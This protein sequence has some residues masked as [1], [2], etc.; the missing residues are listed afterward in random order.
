MILVPFCSHYP[1]L[2]AQAGGQA[3]SESRGSTVKCHRESAECLEDA[4]ESR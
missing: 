3:W 2:D 1:E 4:L